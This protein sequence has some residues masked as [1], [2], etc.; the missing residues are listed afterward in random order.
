MDGSRADLTAK[1]LKVDAEIPTPVD[2]ADVIAE[3]PE[4]T[5][6]RDWCSIRRE[7]W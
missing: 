4:I 5:C 6:A 2:G 3:K 7:R 1:S